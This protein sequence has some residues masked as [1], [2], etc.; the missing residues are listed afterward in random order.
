M[1]SDSRFFTTIPCLVAFSILAGCGGSSNRQNTPPPPAPDTTA[2]SV[3]AIATGAGSTVNRTAT[4]T[5]TANDNV[6]VSEVRFFVD[7][8]LIDAD[9]TSPYSIDWDTSSVTDGDHIL[10]AEAEDAA[11]NVG[12]SAE[13]TVT[14]ANTVQFDVA[15]TGEQEVPSVDSTGTASAG[16]TVNL[17]T[18]AVE[19]ELSITGIDVTAAHIHDAFAGNN[20]PVLIGLEQDATDP[21]IYRVP[22]NAMLDTDG[23][24]KLLAAGLYL[25]AHT[26]ANPG[27]ELRGQILPQ[28]FVLYFTA[29]SGDNEVPQVDTVAGGRAAVTV[30]TVTGA[31]VVQ[32]RVTGLADAS[33]AH[34]HD[35]YAGSNGPVLVGL[36]Q[37]P[38][39]A[40]RWFVEDGVLSAGGLDALAAG[41]LY[42]N[43]HSPA[44][45][46]GEVRGQIIPDG[47]SLL[48]TDLTGAQEVPAVETAASGVGFLTH[49][50]A[51]S[52]LTIHVNTRNLP[53]ASAA[54]LHGAFG[55]T[56]G[57]V[58]IGLMQD[59]SDDSNWFTELAS[60]SAE[61][62]D[63][64]LAGATY[65]NVHTPGNPG[66]EIRG[67]VIPDGIL[68]ATG[69]LEG[70]QEVPAVV[71]SAG[72]TFAVTVDP[73]GPTLEAHA[74]TSG[75]DDAVAAHL[76]DAYAGTSGGV[77]IGLT[78][79]ASDVS[80]WSAAGVTLTAEQLAAFEA[81]RLYVNVHTPANPGGE[82]RG[83]VAPAPVEVLF[84][85][86]SGDQEVPAVAS[87][88]SGVAAVTTNRE[89][90]TVTLHLR[91][92]GADDAVAAHIHGGFAGSNGGVLIGLTQD[93]GDVAHWSVVE[94]QF[95]ETGLADY[96]DGRTYVN[97]HTPA[98]P[99]GEIRGQ[100]VPEAIRVLFSTMDGDQVVPAV[101][102]SASGVA[103]STVNLATRRFVVFVNASGVDDATSAGIHAAPS[104]ANGAQVLPLTQDATDPGQWSA[105]TEPLDRETYLAYR[106]GNLYAQ[107]ATPAE[108]D[109]EIRGQ[110]VPADAGEFDISAP[111]VSV[112]AP[113]G[114]SEVS[115]T[116]ALTATADDNLGVAVVRFFVDGSLIGSDTTEPYTVDWDT[117]AAANGE[118]TLVAEADDAAGNTGT[119]AGVTVTVANA[120]PVSLAQIQAE[121]FTPACSGCHSGPTS[122][123]LPSGMNLSS[124]ADSH[125]AL[126]NVT[127]L[128]VGSL[129]R[130]T[131]G[132]PDDSY[133]IRKLEG[134]QSVGARMP[135][136]GPFLDQATIDTIR[137]W[138]TEGAANN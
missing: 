1:T 41:R 126:V 104:G 78:Q 106:G 7:G 34:V 77:A 4:L 22:A 14:V 46:G 10:R 42:V 133:L 5:V 105:E 92:E 6:G 61:Q 72:G 55:G 114:G 49:D 56:N 47:I 117:T 57:G 74:N 54:H 100:I 68:F 99:G 109:G 53:D 131:P 119:S 2:P 115:G 85:D 25:N 93:P 130:V 60:L 91:A 134:T 90:G 65:L 64:L 39:D 11:G 84:V 59:G 80:R 75:A 21:S 87:A 96:L 111:T 31:V 13:L 8:T 32:A 35:A 101:A 79:D 51:A 102:T 121:V 62:T 30:N 26:A 48:V 44:N 52:R 116:V 112:T 120:A 98:N 73:A 36:S 38:V 45:P 103:S 127:S 129:N 118:A 97:L 3:G 12:Q 24:D 28:D 89:T 71:S 81:G 113:A 16:L 17:A 19:G 40:S 70:S 108:P 135:Q 136:G 137:Q 67:Q 82:I 88:A 63:A 138:I 33:A 107:V 20:G 125:A 58:E 95:D 18:G 43:V 132:N 29:L 123:T 110:I 94:A 124:A 23:I 69:R 37:D 76:H 50:V 128:Q 27:G 86:L 83:Q 9:Q 122:T 66:G 15:L